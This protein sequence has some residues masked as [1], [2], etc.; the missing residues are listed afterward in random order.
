MC[1]VYLDVQEQQATTSE[2]TLYGRK[3]PVGY[4]VKLTQLCAYQRVQAS[5]L[6]PYE[7]AKWQL[8]GITDDSTFAVFRGQDIATTDDV[9][10]VNGD[11]WIPEGWRPFVQCEGSATANV[12]QLVSNGLMF[13]KD[14][15]T[16]G[17]VKTY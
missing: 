10:R 8:I 5:G 14:E 2:G 1:E 13:S 16:S 3:V 15:L 17:E 9:L 7:T 6:D 4:V 11:L 12:I